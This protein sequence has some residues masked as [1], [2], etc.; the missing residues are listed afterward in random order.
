M[1]NEDIIMEGLCFVI[2]ILIIALACVP[3]TSTSKTVQTPIT[4]QVNCRTI[5][6]DKKDLV[7]KLMVECVN[8]ATA[9]TTG[10]DQDANHWVKACKDKLTE[11]YEVDGYQM[12]T[13]KSM[14]ADE[15][16]Y[17]TA[18]KELPYNLEPPKDTLVT[19]DTLTTSK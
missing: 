18:C 2:L 11:I 1:E 3:N 10:E 12:A 19:K 17:I 8:N 15:Y 13:K 14:D 5:P 9:K 16:H 6:E 7:A 4:F